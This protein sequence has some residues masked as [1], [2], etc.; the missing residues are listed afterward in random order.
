MS[1]D[2]PQQRLQLQ[3]RHRPR[4]QPGPVRHPGGGNGGAIYNDGNTITLHVGGSLI[5]DNHANEGGGA[6][7]FVSN[8]LTGTL[9]IDG[10]TLLRNPNDGFETAGF[11]GIFYLG[12][13][14]P[15]VTNS[16]IG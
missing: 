15:V 10:S 8:D 5:T 11:P 7:F 4:R 6:I 12:S 2:D 13:G 9:H 3:H 16:T 14:P 1:W